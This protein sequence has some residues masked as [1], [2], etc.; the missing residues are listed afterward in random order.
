MK[1]TIADLSARKPVWNML[2][3]FY[4]DTDPWI[5][6]ERIVQ[7]C[8]D[9]PYTIEE[10]REILFKE[11]LPACRWNIYPVAPEWTGYPI[12]W[13]SKRI[14]KKHRHGKWRPLLFGYVSTLIWWKRLEPRV[15]AHR[16]G[17]GR[18]DVAPS[19]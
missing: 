7:V 18:L 17:R 14:M 12:E 19:H 1:L 10:L 11:I 15:R 9:S 13:L 8:G 2:Q 4:M 5:L 16:E 6:M 3:M